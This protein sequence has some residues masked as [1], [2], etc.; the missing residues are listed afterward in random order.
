M[1]HCARDTS[2][3]DLGPP[4]PSPN[5]SEACGKTRYCATRRLHV[6]PQRGGSGIRRG[7][8]AGLRAIPLRSYYLPGP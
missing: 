7:P 4:H 1:E 2:G 3:R 5:D 6:P 8:S